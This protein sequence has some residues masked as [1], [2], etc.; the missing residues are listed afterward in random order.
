V[1]VRVHINISVREQVIVR[2]MELFV[3]ASIQNVIARPIMY[4]VERLAYVIVPLSIHVVAQAI[5][6]E[7]GYH[8]EA[9]IRVVIVR[10]ITVGMAVHVHMYIVMCVRAGIQPRVR[11]W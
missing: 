3:K 1:Y 11:G 9:N 5:V 6:L 10:H 8:V 2:V 4:G 7:V